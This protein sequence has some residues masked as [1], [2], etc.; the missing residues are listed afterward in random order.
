[1]RHFPNRALPLAVLTL[2][3]FSVPLPAQTPA[4]QSRVASG[5]FDGAS[6]RP[7]SAHTA[8]QTGLTRLTFQKSYRGGL[9]ASAAGVMLASSLPGASVQSS[10]ALEEVAGTLEG[11]RGTFVLQHAATS[12]EGRSTIV[13]TVVPGSGTGELTGLT[14]TLT[15][16]SGPGTRRYELT[17]RLPAP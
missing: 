10:I 16:I 4:V 12:A 13:I 8:P 3:A 5:E 15:V 17:Y 7:A 2:L 9:E 11:R 6:T 14:G 1:M